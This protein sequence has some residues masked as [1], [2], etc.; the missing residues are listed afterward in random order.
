LVGLLKKILK[1]TSIPWIRILYLHPGRVTDD[2]IELMASEERLCSYI[3]LPLQHANDRILRLM[4]R[5]IT[6]K[7]IVALIKKIRE[8][9]PGVALRTSLIVGFPSETKKEFK[10]LCAFIQRVRFDRLGV[11]AYSREEKTRAYD[12]KKQISQKIKRER[13][14]V[15]MELQSEISKE[16]LR[17]HIGGIE[18]VLVEGKAKKPFDYVGRTRRD[19]PEVDGSFFIK[20][21]RRLN[22]GDLV[23]CRV[24]GRAV[25][26]LKGV[27]CS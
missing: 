4:N 15:L 11:F 12:F 27:V 20:S 14:D 7:E 26:D 16:N 24:T 8:K 18:E 13:Q 9:I 6:Q 17:R 1:V 22:A 2:L 21:F 5:G 25:H 19:A 10:E 3:D 23:P